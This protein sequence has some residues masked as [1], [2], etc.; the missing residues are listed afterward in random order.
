LKKERRIV[1]PQEIL[2]QLQ[3]GVGVFGGTFDPIHIGHVA[4]AEDILRLLD[5]SKILFVPSS[6]PPHKL[7]GAS[8]SGKDRLAMIRLSLAEHEKLEACDLEI[9]LKGPSYS[10]I[11]LK[12][13]YQDHS[14]I[15]FIMGVDSFALMQTWHQYRRIPQF[16]H[17]VIMTRP[18]Y[19]MPEPSHVIPTEQ[20]A[21]KP[22]KK[23]WLWRHESGHL[24][25]EVKVRS[26]DISS[27]QIRKLLADRKDASDMLNPAVRAYIEQK[28]LYL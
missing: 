22:L 23:P 17:L 5:L 3:G 4:V 2:T 7:S 11:T 25:L 20:C 26:F 14:N 6:K 18:G 21:F 10:L 28:G 19:R 8:A 1:I 12:S 24:L 15:A 27:T 9:R 16:A 13:L